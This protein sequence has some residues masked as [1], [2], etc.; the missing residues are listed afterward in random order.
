MKYLLFLLLAFTNSVSSK[1]CYFGYYEV[2]CNIYDSEPSNMYDSESSNNNQNNQK[3]TN[4]SNTE[5]IL[6]MVIGLGISF[7]IAVYKHYRS[8]LQYKNNHP[9]EHLPTYEEANGNN[10]LPSNN[11]QNC[12]SIDCLPT[13]EEAN[14]VYTF[15]TNNNNNQNNDSN[16]HLPTYEETMAE[17]DITIVCNNDYSS[18][19]IN[20]TDT[21]NIN[22]SISVV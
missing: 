13:Y 18:I 6:I 22:H 20:N 10:T 3:D 9:N 21:N 12:N 1:N 7:F 11:R 8:H 2:N 4:N 15:P 5:G 14:A 19:I 17:C 16:A